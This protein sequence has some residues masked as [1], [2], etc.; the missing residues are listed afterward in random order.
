MR[1][2]PTHSTHKRKGTLSQLTALQVNEVKQLFMKNIEE[3]HGTLLL[4]FGA[5]IGL[6]ILEA[7]K[8][9]DYLVKA[10]A[11]CQFLCRRAQGT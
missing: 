6:S 11:I 2:N 10:G 5:S 1:F 8:P 4:K 7:G 9:V 3:K